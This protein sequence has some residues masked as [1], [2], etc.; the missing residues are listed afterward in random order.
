MA[1]ADGAPARAADGFTDST[2]HAQ[3]QLAGLSLTA[4]RLSC[5]G[6]TALFVGLLYV[7]P[8]DV[9]KLPRDNP[10]HIHAR[11]AA[12]T[13]TIVLCCAAARLQLGASGALPA[14]DV[15]TWGATT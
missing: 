13:T 8:A 3:Q 7:L 11:M 5:V 12:V 2:Q 10:R 14:A 1:G 9:R 4:A 6:M 15:E